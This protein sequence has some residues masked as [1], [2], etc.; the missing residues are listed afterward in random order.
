MPEA[1][2]ITKIKH[3]TAG[4]WCFTNSQR[5]KRPGLFQLSLVNAVAVTKHA[6]Y[7]TILCS[8]RVVWIVIMVLFKGFNLLVTKVSIKSFTNERSLEY[9]SPNIPMVVNK[10]SRYIL[11]LI[12]LLIVTEV[13]KLAWLK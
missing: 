10:V 3:V 2:T 12:C 7:G 13:T 8:S 1:A 4:S 6:F 11:I 5:V 9:L